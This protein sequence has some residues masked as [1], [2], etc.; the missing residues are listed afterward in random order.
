MREYL[1]KTIE[2][3]KAEEK[4]T[5]EKMKQAETAAEVRSL[6]KTL[7]KIKEELQD[8]EKQLEKLDDDG[9]G[10]GAGNGDGGEGSGEG[11]GRSHNPLREFRNMQQVAQ[12]NTQRGTQ[13]RAQ[14]EDPT[15]SVEYRTAFMNFVCRGVQIPTELRDNA[16]TTTTDAAAVIPT[17]IMQEIISELSVHGEIYARVRHLNVQGGVEIPIADL[18]PKAVWITADTG[19]SE[20][21][22]QKLSAKEKVSFTYYGLECKLAQS[23]LTSVTTL[24]IFQKEFARLAVEAIAEA[25]DIAIINGTGEGQPLGIINDSRVPAKNVITL[26]AEEFASWSAWKKKVFGKMKKAYRNGTFLMAQGTFDG[27]IDGMVDQNGQPIGRVNYGITDGESY[28]FGGKEV[29]TTEED[30]LPDYDT[31]ASGDVVA[32]FTKL[33]NYGVNT[34]KQMEVTKWTDPDTN[35]LKNKALLIADGKLIDPY[36]TLIIKK[37]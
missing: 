22:E 23:L 28:R 12:H 5:R 31:A 8:A 1:K 11:E 14:D 24:E 35:K 15:N 32:V 18:K 25:L 21:D 37:A 3:K 13:Q 33:S 29:L 36:G 26:T 4:E 6:G 2:R 9:Q 20:S 30:V 19:T 10:A 7:E 27:H 17:T 16:I 34:N